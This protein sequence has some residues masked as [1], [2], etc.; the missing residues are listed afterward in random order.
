[1]KQFTKSYAINRISE[2]HKIIS[3][4]LEQINDYKTQT[5]KLLIENSNLKHS[6]NM[7]VEKIK[8]ETS[9]KEFWHSAYKEKELTN[10]LLLTEIKQLKQ[11]QNQKAIEVLKKLKKFFAKKDK[12]CDAY[13][14]IANYGDILDWIEDKIIEL[15]K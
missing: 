4:L 2:L 8:S 1:M 5:K 13:D 9:E 12:N 10:D 7:Q 15:K 6:P 14:I 11:A 3:E